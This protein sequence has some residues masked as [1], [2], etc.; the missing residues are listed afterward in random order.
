MDIFLTYKISRNSFE[1]KELESYAVIG[2]SDVLTMYNF[3]YLKDDYLIRLSYLAKEISKSQSDVIVFGN[4]CYE[5]NDII[6]LEKELD[7]YKLKISGFYIAS[8][9]ELNKQYI[10]GLNNSEQFGSHFGDSKFEIEK[11]FEETKTV[12]EEIFEYCKKNEIKV[13][14]K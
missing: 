7:Q 5:I 3:D 14:L 8:E 9:F 10:E 2:M 1:K 4:P 6:I 11:A 13:V 12:I